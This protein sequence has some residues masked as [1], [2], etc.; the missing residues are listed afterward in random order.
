MIILAVDTSTPSGSVALLED[1]R[2][3]TEVFEQSRI[4]H[5]ERLMPTIDRILTGNKK[6]IKDVDG[7]A[8]SSGPGSFTALRVGISTVKGLALGTGK[9]VCGISSQEAIAWQL[10]FSNLEICVVTDARKKQVF[11][12]RFAADGRGNLTRLTQ[13]ASLTPDQLIQTLNGPVIFSGNGLDLYRDKL[14]D[15]AP[16][17]SLFADSSLWY[18]RACVVGLMAYGLMQKGIT[19]SA[20]SLTAHYVRPSEAELS[21]MDKPANSKK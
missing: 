18:S 19:E 11:T 9:P 13:D 20:E 5:S 14:E 4:T 21:L 10:R 15:L 8:V 16:S 6:S 1:R 17:G 3:L 12:S 2:I 7:F